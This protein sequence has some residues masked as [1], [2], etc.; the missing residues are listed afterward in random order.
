[1]VIADGA[2]AQLREAVRILTARMPALQQPGVRLCKNAGFSV[3]TP[4]NM[5]RLRG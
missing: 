4:V 2:D 3:L 1:M 5:E